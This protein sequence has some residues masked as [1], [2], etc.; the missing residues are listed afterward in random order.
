MIEKTPLWYYVL[1]EAEVFGNGQH[2]GPLGSRIVA[3]TLCGLVIHGPNT[4]WN[5]NG[6]EDG[7]WHPRDTVQPAGEPVTSYEALMR[8]AL[9]L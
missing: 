3:E 6:S 4:Y 2:L 1:K 7:R 5:E 8:A 9:F